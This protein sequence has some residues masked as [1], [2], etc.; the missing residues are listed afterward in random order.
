MS[1][2]TEVTPAQRTTTIDTARS[3]MLAVAV[4]LAIYL[5]GNRG[6]PVRVVTGWAPDGADLTIIELVV[7]TVVAV[8]IAGALLARMQR[9]RDWFDRWAVMVAGVAVL[10]ALP[11]WRLDVD[12]GS[13]LTLTTMHLATGASALLSHGRSRRHGETRPG[14]RAPLVPNNITAHRHED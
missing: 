2:R 8:A 12:T 5:V 11:L 9:G 4:N 14:G 3:V 10:S 7:T 1:D 13:K 6:S